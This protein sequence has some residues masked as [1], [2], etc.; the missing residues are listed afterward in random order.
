MVHNALII[1][2]TCPG[3]TWQARY[4]D[5]ID[6]GFSACA[7]SVG[8]SGSGSQAMTGLAGVYRT[9]REDPRL[10]LALSADDIRRAHASGQLAVLLHFQG[11]QELGYDPGLVEVFWRLGLRIMG[12]AYN[13]R[14]PVCDGCEEPSDAGLSKLGR[15]VITEMNRLGMVVDLSHTGWRSCADALAASGDPCIASHSNAHAVQPHPRN[16]PDDIIRGIAESGGLIG[17]NGFPAFVSADPA[18][19]MDNL[20]DHMVHIDS[21]VGV[22]HVGLGL[23]YCEMSD[24]EYREMIDTGEW[25]KENYPPPP[26]NY[27]AGIETAR[28]IDALAERM[29]ARGYSDTEIHGVLGAN[30]LRLFERMWP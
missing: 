18:P 30:W 24:A 6:G 2:G 21:L 14:G 8:G 3:E 25:T 19:T 10:V 5:W 11:T 9:I 13:R 20:I 26:W 15:E 23:D 1:D 28:T 7:L 27:P 4:Q 16:L 22:G 29:S 12:L 17:M